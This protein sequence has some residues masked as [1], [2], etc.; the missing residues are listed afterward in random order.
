MSLNRLQSLVYLTIAVVVHPVVDLGC[1]GVDDGQVVVTVA[2][3]CPVFA[4][5]G[6]TEGRSVVHIAEAIAIAVEAE[7][8]HGL[9]ALHGL[10]KGPGAVSGVQGR[11]RIGSGTRGATGNQEIDQRVHAE[12]LS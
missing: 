6:A 10:R 3:G 4:G 1:A 11:Q 12:A 8:A 5:H 9:R 2:D 7:D